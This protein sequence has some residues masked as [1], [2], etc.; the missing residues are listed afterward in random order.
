MPQAFFCVPHPQS[1]FKY[2][3]FDDSVKN[4]WLQCLDTYFVLFSINEDTL[5]GWPDSVASEH[6]SIFCYNE[7]QCMLNSQDPVEIQQL[8]FPSG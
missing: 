1:S 2:H 3:W 6:A 7:Y 4:D 8:Q 5:K